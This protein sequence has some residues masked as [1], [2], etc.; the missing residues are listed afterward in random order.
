MSYWDF[1]ENHSLNAPYTHGSAQFFPYHRAML[2]IWE[3]A[4]LSTGIWKQGMPYIDF[5]A[6][7]NANVSGLF[8]SL[9]RGIT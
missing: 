4:L 5:A 2:H 3:Q 1:T 9:M 7:S 8:A 6:N